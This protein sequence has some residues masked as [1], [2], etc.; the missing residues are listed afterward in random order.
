VRI[1]ALAL[2]GALAFAAQAHAG[3]YDA[4]VCQAAPRPSHVAPEVAV[5]A[6][7]VLHGALAEDHGGGIQAAVYRDGRLIWSEAVG[8]AA[9]DPDRP[10]NGR[11]QMRIGSVSKLFTALAAARLYASG[12]LRLDA[13]VQTYVPEFP[14]K[15]APITARQLA[16]HTS[17]LRQYDFGKLSEAN[18]TTHYASLSE[19]LKLFAND[20]LVAEPGARVHYSSFGFNLLGVMVERA[21]GRDYGAAM[22]TLVAHP[23]GLSASTLDDARAD[24]PCRTEFFTILGGRMRVRAPGRD[25]SDYYPSSGLL[26]TAEDLA[27]LA[28]GA[29]RG[30]ALPPAMR[31]LFVTPL[32]TNDGR[33]AYTFGWQIG[34]DP[35]GRV[36]WYGHG[37]TTNGSYASV[38]YY[39]ASRTT[40]AVI[41]NYNLWLTKRPPAVLRAAR[42]SL[43]RIFEVEA[44]N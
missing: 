44:K 1:E 9:T 30:D 32:A 14:E 15:A 38:R 42:E 28:D 25:S 22:Q 13:P 35:D 43:P 23:L 4:Q 11:T 33:P 20:P 40:V 31:E 24:L 19:A 16:S 26:S 12:Q 39:P 36:A 41:A 34:L 18:N 17:G 21:A 6:R 2:A 29:L 10:L 5:A 3:G 37:G 7:G 27:R 8:L